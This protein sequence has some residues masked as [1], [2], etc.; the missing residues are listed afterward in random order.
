MDRKITGE[1]HFQVSA[2]NFAVSP[3]TTGYTL[4]YSAD[5]INFTAWEEKTPAN[6]TLVVSGAVNGMYYYLAGNGS[7]VQITWEG[8]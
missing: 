7:E 3:S 1:N 2:T 6:E 4:M 5:G 8:N